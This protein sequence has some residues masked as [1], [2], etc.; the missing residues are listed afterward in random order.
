MS[1]MDIFL[2]ASCRCT[3]NSNKTY[4]PVEDATFDQMF[5]VMCMPGAKWQ[6]LSENDWPVCSDPTTTTPAP[7][8]TAPP[9]S[10][11]DSSFVVIV[12]K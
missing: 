7:T 11:Y 9:T 5:G 2:D 10:K 6:S 3:V 4:L 1:Y 12:T 8:T